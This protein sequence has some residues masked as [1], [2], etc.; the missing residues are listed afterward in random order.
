MTINIF[1]KHKSANYR[2][3]SGSSSGRPV[4]GSDGR[5]I[6]WPEMD[7]RAWVGYAGRRLPLLAA[8]SALVFHLAVVFAFLGLSVTCAWFNPP[9]TSLMIER[10]VGKQFVP[11]PV[12]FV[13][14]KN[15]PD[16]VPTMYLRLEDKTFYQHHG[17]EPAAIVYAYSQNKRWGRVVMG[18][19]TI[20]QQL[21]RSM[22]LS[23]EKNYLRKYVEAIGAVT[24][25]AVLDKKRIFELYLNYIEWGKGVY[26]LGAAAQYYYKKPGD[27]LSY[28]EYAR[29]AAVII[30]PIN[31]DVNN[32]YN[33]PAM[34]ARYYVLT[35]PPESVT[36]VEPAPQDQTLTD[37]PAATDEVQPEAEAP[38]SDILP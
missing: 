11:R 34:A 22:F 15:L 16:A 8:G 9:V 30:N 6:A 29:L 5:Q 33:Q 24:F 20:T 13:P 18:G 35:A 32:F 12:V 25:D 7:G 28:D 10:L 19:S 38:L 21:V 3:Q 17:I 37:E 23:P 2:W 4:G 26:G 31:Y 14:F 27:K 1:Q 36:E